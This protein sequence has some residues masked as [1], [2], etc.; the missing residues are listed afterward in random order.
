M[1]IV[2]LILCFFF[3][4]FSMLVITVTLKSYILILHCKDLFQFLT[5]TK[6]II[7]LSIFH[8]ISE[9]RPRSC[10][11]FCSHLARDCQQ[12]NGT[13]ITGQLFDKTHRFTMSWSLL[14]LVN[15]FYCCGNEA[16]AKDT[17]KSKAAQK[18][19]WFLSLANQ[20]NSY[21]N[22]QV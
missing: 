18:I 4:I 19:H 14:Q 17:H 8:F 6:C 11:R 10:V 13:V 20:S 5:E 15:Y 21:T 12:L 22:L 16:N 9:P 7:I 1:A 2:L 3:R